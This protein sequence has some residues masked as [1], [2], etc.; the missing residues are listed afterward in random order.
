MT[1]VDSGAYIFK[2]ENISTDVILFIF[3]RIKKENFQ[4]CMPISY[5]NAIINNHDTFYVL[6]IDGS[7][8]LGSGEIEQVHAMIADKNMIDLLKTSYD[9]IILKIYLTND[10]HTEKLRFA[11]T[12]LI[13]MLKLK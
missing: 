10:Q 3:S 7:D 9:D 1:T 2:D 8:Y 11:E 12:Q 6:F 4:K 5:N 13:S